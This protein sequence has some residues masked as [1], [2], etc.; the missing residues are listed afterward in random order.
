MAKLTT[1]FVNN[2][3]PTNQ[4]NTYWDEGLKGFGLV[5]R[6]SGKKIFL[7]KYRIGRGRSAPV[8]KQTIGTTSIIKT[9][10]A[11][12]KAK[13][14]FSIQLEK[15]SSNHPHKIFRQFCNS[16]IFDTVLFS[17]ELDRTNVL[18]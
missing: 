17:P 12:L 13:S 6:P 3:K 8:R 16:S 1:K 18:Q 2:I 11:R 15:C 10:Q 5:V 14:F 4:I 7:L 9:E